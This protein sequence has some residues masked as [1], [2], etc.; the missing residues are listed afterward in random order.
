MFMKM[1]FYGFSFSVIVVSVVGLYFC[2]YFSIIET[3][4]YFL[5]IDYISINFI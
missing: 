4:L 5:F 1:L 3:L 2:T